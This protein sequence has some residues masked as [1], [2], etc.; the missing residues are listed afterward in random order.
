ML[1]AFYLWYN[2]KT[3]NVANGV[4]CHGY[5]ASQT[6]D[7]T[8]SLTQQLLLARRMA[9]NLQVR[10]WDVREGGNKLELADSPDNICMQWTSCSRTAFALVPCACV[11]PAV[12]AAFALLPLSNPP[13]FG[14]PSFKALH[15]ASWPLQPRLAERKN[16]QHTTSASSKDAVQPETQLSWISRL[17]K[18]TGLFCK[19]AL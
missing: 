7:T 17:L 13:S 6:C 8:T 12:V 18:I 3:A 14:G 19:R 11:T 2:N 1:R 15:T 5:V 16:V 4:W 9:R 10:V